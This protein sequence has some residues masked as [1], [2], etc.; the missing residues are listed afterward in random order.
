MRGRSSQKREKINSN[1]I[2][3]VEIVK[4]LAKLNN[5]VSS[6]EP[7]D[8]ILLDSFS[9]ASSPKILVS[10]EVAF[11]RRKVQLKSTTRLKKHKYSGSKFERD[12]DTLKLKFFRKKYLLKRSKNWT[13]CSKKVPYIQEDEDI[14]IKTEGE[15]VREN[16]VIVI[17]SGIEEEESSVEEPREIDDGC[18]TPEPVQQDTILTNE[19]IYQIV[20]NF[21]PSHF[22]H[23]NQETLHISL[24]AQPF[25]PDLEET[26]ENVFGL[27]EVTIYV[28]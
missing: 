3:R 26:L 2:D 7:N 1:D 14:S 28:V 4:D 12:H 18:F 21:Q 15:E 17:E 19:R 13:K 8:E 10:E 5:N 16:E 23:G 22:E 25:D 9:N 11:V 6:Y 27:L 24:D 20:E